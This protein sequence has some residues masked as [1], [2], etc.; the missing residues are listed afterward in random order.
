MK[1]VVSSSVM[2]FRAL[3]MKEYEI[4]HEK[5]RAMYQSIYD[6]MSVLYPTDS[7]LPRFA[8]LLEQPES[9]ELLQIVQYFIQRK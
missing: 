5:R 2:R 8:E 1:H 7:H 3:I 4:L 9:I 6:K